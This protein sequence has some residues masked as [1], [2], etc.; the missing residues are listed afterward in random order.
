MANVDHDIPD[1]T[2]EPPQLGGCICNAL[3]C[4][5]FWY[6]GELVSVANV[7]YIQADRS[8]YRLVLD[9]GVIHWRNQAESPKPWEVPEEGYDYPHFDLARQEGLIGVPIASYA[10]HASA[11]G[12]SVDFLFTDGRRAIFEDVWDSVRYVVI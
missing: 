10:M 1:I 7:I 3:I 6:R 5:Q 2:G 8:W 11:T 12:C 4:E 9:A